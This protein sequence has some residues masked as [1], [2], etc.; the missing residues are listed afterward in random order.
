MEV[1][2]GVQVARDF[3]PQG[4]V[5]SVATPGG[6]AACT[7]NIGPIEGIS[8]AHA[9]LHDWCAAHG[10]KIGTHSWETYGHW[11]DDPANYE[12]WLTYLLA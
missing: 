6:R 10:H 1:D 4:N 2:F 11:N 5:R 9:A 3:A 8:T 7:L 12:I